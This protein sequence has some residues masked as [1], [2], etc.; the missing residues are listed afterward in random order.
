M[1]GTAEW[2]VELLHR[3]QLHELCESN[4]H[5]HCR[6]HRYT[7]LITPKPQLLLFITPNYSSS[8][9]S[10]L[11]HF[12]VK[13]SILTILAECCISGRQIRVNPPTL[14][15][16]WTLAV[17]VGSSA[18]DSLHAKQIQHHVIIVWDHAIDLISLFIEI[19]SHNSQRWP[20]PN[21]KGIL[22]LWPT[23]NNTDGLN[24]R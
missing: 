11:L 5:P 7:H 24:K 2:S 6:D 16:L 1:S 22:Q 8:P 13:E 12:Y 14:T 9:L 17:K 10:C 19:I 21:S 20:H 4:H 3:L 23:K 15:L 18:V